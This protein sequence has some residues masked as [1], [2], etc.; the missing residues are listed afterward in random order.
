MT[1]A[2]TMRCMSC[3]WWEESC[4]FRAKERDWGLC[5]FWGGKSGHEPRGCDTCNYHNAEPGQRE[6]AWRAG[7]MPAIRLEGAWA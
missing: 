6:A 4:N 3:R 2:R 7:A 1:R 5:H